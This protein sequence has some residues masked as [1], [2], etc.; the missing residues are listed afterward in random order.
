MAEVVPDA[1]VVAPV[2]LD[3]EL[4]VVER[5]LVRPVDQLLLAPEPA[6]VPV[7]ELPEVVRRRKATVPDDLG[8]KRG[9]RLVPLLGAVP[10]GEDEPASGNAAST[11][12]YV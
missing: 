9:E 12:R 11:A 2:V 3:V 7:R 1:L 6:L 5:R 4:T 8:V 10:D